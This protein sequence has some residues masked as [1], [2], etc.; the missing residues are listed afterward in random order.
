[1][2]QNSTVFKIY[3]QIADMDRHYYADHSLTLARHPSETDERMMM[4][5]LAFVMNAQERLEFTRGLCEEDEPDLWL[6]SFADE[7]EL[8]LEVGLPSEKRLKKACNRSQKTVLITYGSD[9]A[10]NPWWEGVKK[11]VTGQKSL[12][13]YRI[14]E[15]QSEALISLAE[16][17]AQISASITDGQIWLSS[18]TGS[19]TIDPQQIYPA[20]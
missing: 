18:E 8:W 15:D 11:L 13:I 10:F 17:G 3:L 2:A 1:M 4:R 12:T 16:R 6:K 7:I 5:L 14:S 9:Q 19:A 20:I